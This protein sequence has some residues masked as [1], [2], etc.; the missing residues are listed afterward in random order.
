MRMLP[1]N[2]NHL[3]EWGSFMADIHTDIPS[4]PLQTP[5][6]GS[7]SGEQSNSSSTM[8]KAKVGYVTSFGNE[9]LSSYSLQSNMTLIRES[10]IVCINRIKILRKWRFFPSFT[11]EQMTQD[12]H[13]STSV[14]CA[15]LI[16]VKFLS[17]C[18]LS[19]LLGLLEVLSTLHETVS[20]SRSKTCY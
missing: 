1:A 9:L 3:S 11:E 2:L 19:H 17:P 5:H 10:L 7:A 4:F 20:D 8:R 16:Y 15:Y 12:V 18:S 13:S 6:K 14:F